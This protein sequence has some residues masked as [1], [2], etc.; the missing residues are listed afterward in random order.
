MLVCLAVENLALPVLQGP[1]A[2]TT[3]DALTVAIFQE[4]VKEFVKRTKKLEENVQLLWALLWG[5]ALDA[6]RTKLE[7]RWDHDD[8]RHQ[9]AGVEL[10]NAIK[11]LMYN[12]QELKYIP[13]AI[14]L[15]HFYSSFQQRHVDAAHYLEQFNNRVDILERCGAAL[16]E[17]LGTMRKVFEQEGINPLT[18]DEEELEQVRAKACEWYLALAFLLGA[19]H[20]CFGQL[21]ETYKN[22]FMQASTGTH[23]QGQMHST[24]WPTIRKTNVT[25]YELPGPTMGWHLPHVTNPT[26]TMTHMRV[27]GLLARTHQRHL[28]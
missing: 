23:E 20:T 3:T 17:D 6:V 12:V 13:L 24:S 21:L 16:G 28:T 15:R 11:D 1:T 7:A 2:P 19:D 25:T 9:S 4:E 22:D 18:A 8:M 27:T 5:Q 14:H 10:L 26:T